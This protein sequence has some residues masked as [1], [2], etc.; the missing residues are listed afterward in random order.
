MSDSNDYRAME[1]EF[2]LVLAP[3]RD[4]VA[5]RGQ[6]ALLYDEAGQEYIDCVAGIGVAS[7]GHAHPKI[8]AAIQKQ[9]ETLITCPHFYHS[10]QLRLFDHQRG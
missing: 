2:G 5:V 4:L 7:L 6:G 3:K 1:H 9:A 8:V 10:V